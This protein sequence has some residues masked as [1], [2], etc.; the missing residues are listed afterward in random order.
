MSHFWKVFYHLKILGWSSGFRAIDSLPHAHWD[1]TEFCFL[2]ECCRTPYTGL[3]NSPIPCAS[4]F[5]TLPFSAHTNIIIQT[6]KKYMI[7]MKFSYY[8]LN[9]Y[10]RI[11][12][13]P[14]IMR[15]TACLVI[16]QP[17]LIAMLHSVI[18]RR[19]VRPRTQWRLRHKAFTSGLGLDAMTLAW[20]TVVQLVVSF[21][22]G[23]QWGISQ[24]YS[25]SFFVSSL[26][27][28]VPC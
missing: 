12:Y 5:S 23:L 16:N 26:S 14:Y 8:L 25:Y 4:P 6:I 17:R 1:E 11:G 15:Q 21:N 22:S 18:A 20:S 9:R 27:R 24:E 28:Q 19:R 10:K 13:N 7:L 2:E 3:A